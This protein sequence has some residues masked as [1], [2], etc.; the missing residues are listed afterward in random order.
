[1]WLVV[2]TARVRLCARAF[3]ALPRQIISAWPSSAPPGPMTGDTRKDRESTTSRE[4]RPEVCPAPYTQ[5]TSSH[6]TLDAVHGR[7]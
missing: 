6:S 5:P 2:M 1:M 7:S 4:G 3:R